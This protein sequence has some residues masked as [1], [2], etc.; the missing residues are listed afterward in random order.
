MAFPSPITGTGQSRT[1]GMSADGRVLTGW[2]VCSGNPICRNGPRQ[3]VSWDSVTGQFTDYSTLFGDFV[4]EAY[5]ANSDGSIV[6]GIRA[7]P[8]SMGWIWRHGEGFTLVPNIPVPSLNA[9][10]GAI[11]DI[12]EDGGVAIGNSAVPFES[13]I[14]PAIWTPEMGNVNLDTF[15]QAMGTDLAQ[16]IT[17]RSPIALTP[18]GTTMAGLGAGPPGTNFGAFRLKISTAIVCFN[19]STGPR[20]LRVGFPQPFR[21]YMAHGSTVGF[22]PTTSQLEEDPGFFSANQ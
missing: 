22:C 8:S 6:A 20:T 2:I 17:L 21:Q 10:L 7:G 18:D 5:S 11:L 12:S 13:L 15:V 4:S 1:N 14:V 3:G 16:W 9:P 19:S